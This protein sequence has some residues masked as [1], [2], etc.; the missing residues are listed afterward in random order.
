MENASEGER[1]GLAGV[2]G[3]IVQNISQSET[4]QRRR[5]GVEMSAKMRENAKK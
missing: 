2:D 1:K 4:W 3:G 5:E